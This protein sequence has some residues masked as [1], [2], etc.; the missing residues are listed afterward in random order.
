MRRKVIRG[1]GLSA[2]LVAASLL[3]SGGCWG[4]LVVNEPS[5]RII[6]VTKDTSAQV[7]YTCTVSNGT[8]VP[9][10]DCAL[11]DVGALCHAFPTKGVSANECDRMASHLHEGDMDSA[12]QSVLGSYDCLIYVETIGVS[13]DW[14]V[15]KDG[16]YGCK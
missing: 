7:I 16:S 12:I 14:G 3:F 9:R 6:T 10:A 5:L 15:A 11:G 13:E 2:L 1:I 4:N 8:G